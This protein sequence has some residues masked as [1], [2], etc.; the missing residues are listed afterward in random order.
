MS[1]T[2]KITTYSTICMII[3]R[4]LRI[5][6]GVHQ[7]QVADWIGKTPSA[8]TKV[9]AG[10]S[11]LQFETFVRVCFSFQVQPSTVMATAERYAALLR[12]Y[13][14]AVLAT[15]LN[16]GEDLLLSRAQEYWGSPGFRVSSTTPAGWGMPSV[17]NGPLY[18]HDRTITLASSI[19][20]ALDESF[21][22][23][24]L[25]TPQLPSPPLQS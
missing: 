13:Q 19:R 18:N 6:R 23:I 10:K 17:L 15:D 20:F 21:R 14:W 25:N 12:Q 24:Q 2:Q 5:E 3:L 22:E 7:A 8:W 9:E 1:E 4:E 16:L 11:P